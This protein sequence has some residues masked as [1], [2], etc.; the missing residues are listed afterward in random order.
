MGIFTDQGLDVNNEKKNNID[1]NF[2]V[3]MRMIL[4]VNVILIVNVKYVTAQNYYRE[5]YKNYIVLKYKF[6]E[7]I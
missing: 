3:F 1:F 6:F 4:L 5:S 2:A 7:W